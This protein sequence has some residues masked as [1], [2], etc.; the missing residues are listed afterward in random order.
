MN[1][2]Y[3]IQIEETT[4]QKIKERIPRTFPSVGIIPYSPKHSLRAYRGLVPIS[5]KTTPKAAKDVSNSFLLSA[6][7]SEECDAD[8]MLNLNFIVSSQRLDLFEEAV[9]MS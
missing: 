3:L 8:S 9:N 4:V 1:T 7:C 2:I 6:L 5:P